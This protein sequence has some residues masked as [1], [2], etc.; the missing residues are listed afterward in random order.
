MHE[1][2][3][4]LFYAV[5]LDSIP[6]DG[7]ENRDEYLY[8]LCSETWIAADAWALFEMVMNGISKWYEW[9][10]TPT[11]LAGQFASPLSNHVQLDLAND[12]NGIRAYVAPVVHA[13]NRIQSELLRT[14]DPRLWNHMESTGIEPQIYGM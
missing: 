14:T 3:A 8:E 9:R 5:S 6:D 10:E 12:G 1:V 7:N 4:P 13:C 11:T 2:L